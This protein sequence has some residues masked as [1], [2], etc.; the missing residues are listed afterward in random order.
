V[1]KFGQNRPEAPSFIAR[2]LETGT[3]R[4]KDDAGQGSPPP[5]LR[6]TSPRSIQAFKK[7]FS[8]WPPLPKNHSLPSAPAADEAEF[9]PR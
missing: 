4:V 6:T 8:C 3:D 1:I 9:G 5:P 2:S 7:A